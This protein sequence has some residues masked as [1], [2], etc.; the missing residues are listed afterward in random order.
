MALIYLE[1]FIEAPVETCFDLARDVDVH[2][3]STRGTNEKAVGGVTSG[4]LEVGDFVT[5]EAKHL[6][7]KQTL[8]AQITAM[9]RPDYFIDEMVSGA[10]HSFVHTHRFEE[11]D[12]VTLMID[13]FI[14]KA[15]FGLA[16]KIANVAFLKRYMHRFLQQRATALKTI[17]ESS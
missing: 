2:M 15:P 8:T 11:M 5:W 7:V 10:F 16:G 1:T 17:A 13:Q 4:L 6:G 3:K 9:N 12:G 14:Y